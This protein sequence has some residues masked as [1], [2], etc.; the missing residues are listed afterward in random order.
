[1]SYMNIFIILTA[2]CSQS[3]VLSCRLLSS[4]FTYITYR[5]ELHLNLS[6]LMDDHGKHLQTWE[7][8]LQYLVS[9]THH[10]SAIRLGVGNA[11]CSSD[12]SSTVL[13]TD[14]TERLGKR[15]LFKALMQIVC[16]TCLDVD[17]D[18]AA[19][20]SFSTVTDHGPTNTGDSQE[21]Q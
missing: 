18:A 12:V 17:I 2:T 1:M 14:R 9:Y 15:P 5:N 20:A 3:L 4:T 10:Y 6:P 13:R 8:I 7:S 16:T 19:D 21:F 11:T